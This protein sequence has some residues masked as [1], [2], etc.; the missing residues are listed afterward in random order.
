MLEKAGARRPAEEREEAGFVYY[1]RHFRSRD[2]RQP[3]PTG[4]LLQHFHG[5]SVL[6]LPADGDTWGVGFVMSSRDQALRGLRDVAAWER[7]MALLPELSMWCDGEPITDIQVIA[8]HRGLHTGASSWTATRSSPGWSP[9]ATPGRAP[10]PRSGE[11]RRSGCCTRWRSATCCARCLP[12]EPERLVREFDAV[13]EQTV[14]PWYQRDP[15]L[16]P[17]PAGR[18]RCGRSPA[19]RTRPRTRLGD[20]HGPLRGGSPRP[21]RPACPECDRL[22]GGHAVRGLGRPRAGREGDRAR[23]R[24]PALPRLRPSARR[25]GRRGRGPGATGAPG[26]RRRGATLRAGRGRRRSGAA[27]ARL[28]GHPCPVAPPGRRR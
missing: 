25:S 20:D 16:R 11:V 9:S 12:S 17:A 24:R 15:R 28:A 5:F 14:A 10:T 27:A 13:T 18:D 4:M 6:T 26:G 19:R 22:T 2:G 1:C 8:G 7:A 21:R 23:R 3:A